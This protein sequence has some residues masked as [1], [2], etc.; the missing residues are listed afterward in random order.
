MNQ[1]LGALFSGKSVWIHGPESSSKASPE[2]GLGPWIGERSCVPCIWKLP[3]GYSKNLLGTRRGS[4]KPAQGFLCS[5][6]PQLPY[7]KSV[8]VYPVHGHPERA[9]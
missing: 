9:F 7:K 1:S 4:Q 3:N 2:T 8:S 6:R 5:G